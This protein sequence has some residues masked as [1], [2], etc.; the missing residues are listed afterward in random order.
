LKRAEQGYTA[1]GQPRDENL[2]KQLED[3]ERFRRMQGLGEDE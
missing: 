1:R 3:I 2:R